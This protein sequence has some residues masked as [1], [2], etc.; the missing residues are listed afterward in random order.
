[1]L[2]VTLSYIGRVPQTIIMFLHI[3]DLYLLL[4][5]CCDASNASQIR[6]R[7]FSQILKVLIIMTFNL[8]CFPF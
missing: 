1:M 6:A 2:I 8:G 7:G 4:K 5:A 3:Q